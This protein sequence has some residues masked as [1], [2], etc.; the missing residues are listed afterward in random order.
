MDRSRLPLTLDDSLANLP[1]AWE[2]TQVD[3]L[4]LEYH[5]GMILAAAQDPHSPSLG[6][7]VPYPGGGRYEVLSLTQVLKLCPPSLAVAHLIDLANPPFLPIWVCHGNGKN[8]L[9]YTPEELAQ[10]LARQPQCYG[11]TPEGPWSVDA[12]DPWPFPW[13]HGKGP[14][15]PSPYGSYAPGGP[16]A[17]FTRCPLVYHGRAIFVGALFLL[18][19]PFNDED[20]LSKGLARKVEPYPYAPTSEHVLTHWWF[21]HQRLRVDYAQRYESGDVMDIAWTIHPEPDPKRMPPRR[22]RTP[23]SEHVPGP[24]DIF[25]ARI[26][27]IIQRLRGTIKADEVSP[28]DVYED[29][30]WRQWQ[31]CSSPASFYRRL[32]KH[33]INF[34]SLLKSL[35]RPMRV[36]Q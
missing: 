8:V 17:G 13:Q 36:S 27:S 24:D 35:P 30:E 32:A 19:D 26:E 14:F 2:Q 10:E 21:M 18:E 28:R 1:L 15:A 4:Y 6:Y 20:L 22:G 34:P 33:H 9:V 23:G 7:E 25:Q 5:R 31:N 3:D 11:P 29:E 12:A 16:Q